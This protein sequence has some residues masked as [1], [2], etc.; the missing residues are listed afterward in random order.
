[1]KPSILP[2]FQS[3]ASVAVAITAFALCGTVG[4]LQLSL[5]LP[6]AA[7]IAIAI[8]RRVLH[9]S[10][11]GEWVLSVTA[12]VMALGITLNTFYFTSVLGGSLDSPVLNNTD[13]LRYFTDA[14]YIYHGNI[15]AA[16]GD[17]LGIPLIVAALWVVL[18]KSIVWALAACMLLT[19]LAISL[20]GR[21]T[22]LLLR[23]GEASSALA[24]ALTAAVCHFT[25]Q[26]M[27]LLK[28][29][30]IYVAL[31]LTA[32]PL[33]HFYLGN[34]ISPRLAASF[35]VGCILTALVRSHALHFITLGLLMFLPL[36]FTR[37]RIIITAVAAIC[38]S[39]CMVG[40]GLLSSTDATKQ[41]RIASGSGSM[42][43]SY[44]GNDSR[45]DG[46]K[47]LLGDY[48]RLP[49]YHRIALLPATAAVQY[50]VP[51]PWNYGR[52]TEFGYS[53][54]LNHFAWPWY[55]I[56]GFIIFY[57]IFL[58]LKKS[59]PLRLWALWAIICWLIPA[60]LFGGSVSRYVMPFIPLLVP[61]AV[62]VIDELRAHRHHTTFKWWAACYTSLLIVGLTACYFIQNH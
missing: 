31:L 62:I 37:K 1:M 6:V 53:Q 39:A 36:A 8:H 33:A 27:V 50:V 32:I 30:L 35:I 43:E 9:G 28:D 17:F 20:S 13:A 49:I 55:A 19:L 11:A 29:P 4:G 21:L 7:A 40:G 59:T 41:S 25:G 38:I 56:G 22:A 44:L 51:F 61:L 26:G 60:Y 18:G 23:R 10:Q 45:Y 15:S 14:E 54:A 34:R 24:M 52:D 46:Y 12:T 16:I 47:S 3:A 48:Y 42:A 5:S 2:L 58:W 57:F